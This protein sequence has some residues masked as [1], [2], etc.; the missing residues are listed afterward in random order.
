MTKIKICIG[1]QLKAV[2]SSAWNLLPLKKYMAAVQYSLMFR[3][4]KSGIQ[5]LHN[6]K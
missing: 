3:P 4:D 2:L 5:Q 6:G 1:R